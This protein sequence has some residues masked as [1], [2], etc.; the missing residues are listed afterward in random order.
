VIVEHGFVERD[1]ERFL[2]AEA[3]RILELLL[4][5]DSDQVEHADADAVARDAEPHV[6]AREL[7]A[8][9]ELLQRERER[10]R[11]ADFAADHDTLFERLPCHLHELGCAVV[12]HAGSGE[13]RR[14][15]LEADEALDLMPRARVR[16]RRRLRHGDLD[17]AEPRARLL[18]TLRLR[19]LGRLLRLGLLRLRL[20]DLALPARGLGLSRRGR[21]RSGLGDGQLL[22]SG[23]RGKLG[24]GEPGLRRRRLFDRAQ[25]LVRE[26]AHLCAPGLA[27]PQRDVLR[28]HRFAA[29]LLVARVRLAP[30]RDLLLPDRYRGLGERIGRDTGGRG[31][32]RHRVGRLAPETDLL[33]PDRIRLGRREQGFGSGHGSVE[34]GHRLRCRLLHLRDLGELALERELLHAQRLRRLRRL[35]VALALR[36]DLLLPDRLLRRRRLVGRSIVALLP[37]AADLPFP[38]RVAHALPPAMRRPAPAPAGTAACCGG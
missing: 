17:V 6:L 10:L 5:V 12:R 31:L 20:A 1:R 27:A 2:R 28:P 18:L 23:L 13:L 32:E 35:F 3:D 11:V 38:D 29:R 33:L 26:R 19:L 25:R 34:L 4:V 16:L 9:E 15:D 21:R 14:A 24:P 36:P 37:L 22:G 7:V 30:E 8:R